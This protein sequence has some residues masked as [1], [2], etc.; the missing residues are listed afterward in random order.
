ME[1]AF[2]IDIILLKLD[3]KIIAKTL[4]SSKWRLVMINIIDY[5]YLIVNKYYQLALKYI[6]YSQNITTG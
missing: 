2:K 1:R 4:Y 3:V 6:A 5:F